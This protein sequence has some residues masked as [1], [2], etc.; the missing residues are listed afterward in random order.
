MSTISTARQHQP[1]D[2]RRLSSWYNVTGIV[3][4]QHQ[5]MNVND[6]MSRLSIISFSFTFHLLPFV[7]GGT[8]KRHI[9]NW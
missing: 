4:W 3:A 7:I 6:A 9:L 2:R 5:Q 1:P 8:V